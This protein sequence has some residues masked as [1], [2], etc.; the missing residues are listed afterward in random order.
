MNYRNFS[1]HVYKRWYTWSKDQQY[2]KFSEV[3][4]FLQLK[5][6]LPCYNSCDSV[7]PKTQNH[8]RKQATLDL[9]ENNFSK[10]QKWSCSN[11]TH[12][13]LKNC[14]WIF[15]WRYGV[16]RTGWM[17]TI[18]LSFRFSVAN[19]R[20]ST[21]SVSTTEK[22]INASSN[23]VLWC[24]PDTVRFIVR[25]PSS[26]QPLEVTHACTVYQYMYF[27]ALSNLLTCSLTRHHC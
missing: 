10:T 27:V 11:H 17:F 13:K 26:Q 7:K 1:V 25:H 23:N 2:R 19:E 16:L 8:I 20:D 12:L 9:G 3:Q 14:Y 15:D 21:V 24:N 22:A 5:Q 6:Y 4:I 18:F